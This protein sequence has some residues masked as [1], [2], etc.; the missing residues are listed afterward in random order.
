VVLINGK[1]RHQTAFVALFG[2]RGRGN[3]GIDLNAFPE[4]SVDRI[5]ILRDGAS[6]QYGSDAM[7]GVI[8]VILK[9]DINHWTINTGISGY[10]DHKY[11]SLNSYDP[12]QYYTGNQIDGVTYSFSANNGWAIGKNGGFINLSFDFLNSGKTYRQV[13]DTNAAS[14]SKALPYANTGRRAFGDGSLTTAG[15]M[16]NMEIPFNA[17]KTV[18][19]YSF[20]GYNYKS[21]DAFAYSRNY[22]AK[23]E[24]FPTNE[25]GSLIFVPTLCANLQTEKFTL[26]RI[27][28]HTSLMNLSL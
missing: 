6:A 1:R 21:S 4:A 13:P 23:P 16:Y 26:T 2:T 27:F 3:S 7:A 14:N 24:R 15:G 22:S 20:G 11:N 28:K 19:F 8:N 18:S 25:D 5:E 10:Y 17:A 9:R 12:T